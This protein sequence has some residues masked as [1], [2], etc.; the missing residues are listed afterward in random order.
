MLQK[1]AFLKQGGGPAE[2]SQEDIDDL[3]ELHGDVVS[4]LSDLEAALA[5]LADSKADARAVGKHAKA[6]R[7]LWAAVRT[8]KGSDHGAILHTWRGLL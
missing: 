6:I 1:L 5:G 8:L 7:D 2:V 4:R 3:H